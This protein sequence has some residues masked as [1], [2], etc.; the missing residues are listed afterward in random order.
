LSVAIDITERKR[1]EEQLQWNKSLLEM[2]SNSSPLGF[3]VVDNRTDDILYFNKRFCQIWEIEQLEEQ[4]LRGELKNNDIIPY[5]LPVL[6]DVNDFVESCEPLQDENNRTVVSD[7]IQFTNN[8]IIHR[9]STQIRGLDDKYYGRFY[10]FEDITE[11]KRAQQE[12][13]NARNEAERANS[14]KS[15]F[16]SRM[17]HELRTPMNSILGFAQLLEMGVL[18]EKQERGVNHILKS[19]RYLLNMINEVLE[20]SRIESGKLSLSIEPVAV[21]SVV[22][23]ILDFVRP[24]SEQ[25]NIIILNKSMSEEVFINAD[26]Q[27]LKQILLNL[28]INAIKYNNEEGEVEIRTEITKSKF[29]SEDCMRI[30]I[31]DTGSGISEENVKKLF[32]PFERIGAEK[33]TVEGTGLGLAVSKKLTEA[34]EGR[35]GVESQLEKGSVFWVEFPLIPKMKNLVNKI[36]TSQE[37]P[38]F[39]THVK[40][41]VLYIEDNESNIELIKQVLLENRP[42]VK[43]LYEKDGSNSINVALEIKPDL[44]LLDLNLPG[45]QGDEILKEILNNL[46]LKEIPVIII[47]ADAMPNQIKNLLKLGAQSY[48]T[49]PIII[50]QLLKIIDQFLLK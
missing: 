38:L 17:S 26:K 2:M 11:E 8:R 6:A 29:S 39:K 25:R 22:S 24:Q 23:E 45:I 32:N 3:V 19:G 35:I 27:K 44:I 5:C 40:G 12:L 46:E 14:A 31:Y 42:S 36:E 15:E 21:N 13:R 49:K 7:E 34:M 18:N 9:Y 20:L 28:L 47:S 37:A 1:A 10:I 41:T 16:L 30:S 43:L 50:A 4:M 33:T 48:L